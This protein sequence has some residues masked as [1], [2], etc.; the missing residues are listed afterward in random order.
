MDLQLKSFFSLLRTTT[1]T[2]TKLLADDKRKKRQDWNQV[3]RRLLIIDYC[4]ASKFD[5][6][7]GNVINSTCKIFSIDEL[8]KCIERPSL[9]KNWWFS[10]LLFTCLYDEGKKWMSAKD[11]ISVKISWC[12]TKRS[13]ENDFSAPCQTIFFVTFDHHFCVWGHNT[14]KK[15]PSTAWIEA[16]KLGNSCLATFLKDIC[17]AMNSQ[18]EEENEKQKG[19][20]AWLKQPIAK[21][22]K[23]QI[24]LLLYHWLKVKRAKFAFCGR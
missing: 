13:R 18:K 23:S 15:P 22:N 14:P 4:P 3:K 20:A 5:P 9:A 6:R 19:I 24:K 1:H 8:L 12:S 17:W 11:E 2:H 21:V 7:K 16:V 10:L